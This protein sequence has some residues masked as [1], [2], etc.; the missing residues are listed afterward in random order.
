MAKIVSHIA[1]SIRGSIAG[2]TYLTTPSGAIIARQR[3]IPVNPNTS[4]QAKIRSALGG[5]AFQWTT[6]TDAQRKAWNDA[7]GTTSYLL[8]RAISTPGDGRALFVATGSFVK[9]LYAQGILDTSFDG[10]APNT[11]GVPPLQVINI[12]YGGAA[13]TTGM[14]VKLVNEH[15]S[16]DMRCLIWKG[17]QVNASRGY[18]DGPWDSADIGIEEVGAGSTS[19][20]NI[21]YTQNPLEGQKLFLRIVPLFIPDAPFTG[22]VKGTPQLTSDILTTAEA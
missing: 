1:S 16:R 18:Y 12:A 15:E 7:A 17:V 22:F 13:G 5:A 11:T 19:A 9:Y 3:V 2:I 20:V 10:V 14:S 21:A 8:G 6:L 4:A